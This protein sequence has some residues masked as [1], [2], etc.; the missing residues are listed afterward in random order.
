MAP[1]REKP[2]MLLNSGSLITPLDPSC[3]FARLS[4]ILKHMCLITV[5]CCPS[6]KDECFNRDQT[7]TKGI[8]HE[9]MGYTRS[10]NFT[11]LVYKDVLKLGLAVWQLKWY[12][13]G[14]MPGLRI[15]QARQTLSSLAWHSVLEA[16]HG[17]WCW[18]LVNRAEA[19]PT[20]PPLLKVAWSK[21][22]K[23]CKNHIF[24]L[25]SSCAHIRLLLQFKNCMF[26][27]SPY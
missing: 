4:F 22:S 24:N 10:C 9:Q 19:V 8:K 16:L 17:K 25:I 2:S 12:E 11:F 3:M 27:S 14:I 20:A 23:S 5:Q 7:E 15:P 1:Q 13:H 26:S 21:I 18:I 6:Q